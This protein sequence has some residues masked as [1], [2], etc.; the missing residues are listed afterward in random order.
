MACEGECIII[1]STAQSVDWDWNAGQVPA[2]E[3]AK[4]ATRALEENTKWEKIGCPKCWC[5]KK[6]KPS[7]RIT[8]EFVAY[9]VV[10]ANGSDAYLT[11]WVTVLVETW[12]G[13]CQDDM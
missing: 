7:S 12:Q 10:L 8:H 6:G 9:K 11:G 4:L 5:K 3:L 1:E 13:N 2:A